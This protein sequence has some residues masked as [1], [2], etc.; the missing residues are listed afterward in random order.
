MTLCL[1]VPSKQFSD[2]VCLARR[3]RWG[4]GWYYKQGATTKTY[5]RVPFCAFLVPHG[6]VNLRLILFSGPHRRVC[7]VSSVQGEEIKQRWRREAPGGQRS[8][9]SSIHSSPPADNL[10]GGWSD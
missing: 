2:D 9:K 10:E 5:Y 6:A 1:V 3:P 8:Q 4:F 7:G